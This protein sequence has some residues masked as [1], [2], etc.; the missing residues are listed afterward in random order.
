MTAL[1]WLILWYVAAVPLI[2]A[3]LFMAVGCGWLDWLI[4]PRPS[5]SASPKKQENVDGQ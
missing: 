5:E 1:N 3:S 4:M 2:M